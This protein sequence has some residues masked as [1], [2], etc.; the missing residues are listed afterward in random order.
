MSL[1]INP[2]KSS[3]TSQLEDPAQADLVRFSDDRPIRYLGYFIILLV[4]VFFGGWAYWAPL[5]SA[6]LAPG[7]IKV[8]GDHKR[9]QHL[10]GGIVKAIHV[11]NGDI[12]SKGQILIELEDT[13]SKAQLQTLRGQFFS[14]LAREARLIA[15]RDGKSAIDYPENLRN[16]S[17]DVRAQ[18]AMRVQ[19]QSFAVRKQSRH[20]QIEILNEQHQQLLAKIEGIKSQKA[21]R[22]NLANSLSKDLADMRAM[23]A[24]GYVERPKVSELERRLTEAQGDHGNFVADIATAQTQI[25]EIALK[26][27]QIEK[28]FQKEVI[29][30]LSKVQTEL[31]ELRE[32][33]EWLNDTVTR[34]L[35]KAPEAGMVMNLKIDTLGAVIAPGSQPGQPGE[36]GNLLDIVPQQQKLIVEAR[37]SPVD[38]DRVHIGQSTEVRF[39]AFKSAKTPKV[40][41][42][43]MKLSA[44]IMLDERNQQQPSYYL[45]KV[46]VDKAGLEEL[47]KRGLILMP[48]MPAEVLINTG[49]RTFFEYLAQ[50]F[51]NIFARSLI[52]D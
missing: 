50:P 29:D 19:T 4:F 25:S 28:D 11:H 40:D 12:V 42:R 8:E 18:E 34:T 10:E 39:S 27:L 6:A 1:L 33:I 2:T 41:G 38:I 3:K 37:V 21:S 17:K 14:A 20:G 43:L 23:L 48:G 51:S 47:R 22:N 32:K 16:E 26:V 35:I 13:S 45:A 30:E 44:D 5:G 15:E 24:K 52:E 9:V 49:D 46:D 31:S 7:I 36:G